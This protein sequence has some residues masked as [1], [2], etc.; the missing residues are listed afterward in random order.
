MHKSFKCNYFELTN[1]FCAKIIAQSR[2]RPVSVQIESEPSQSLTLKKLN[3][4][5]RNSTKYQK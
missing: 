1:G 2:N 4:E 5:Q 3:G